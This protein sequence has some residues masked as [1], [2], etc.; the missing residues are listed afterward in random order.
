MS[1]DRRDL[2]GLGL[3][4]GALA[5]AV[6]LRAAVKGKAVSQKIDLWPNGAPEAAPIGLGLSLVERSKDRAIQDRSLMGVTASWLDHIRAKGGNGAAV[7]A[8]P[9]GGYHHLAWDKEGLD[10]AA[11]FAARGVAGFALAYRL[12]LDGWTGGLDTPLADAQRAV[13]VVRGRAAEFGID[14]T[15]IAVIGFSAGGHLAANLAAQFDRTVYPRQDDFDQVSARPDLAAPIYPLV[16]ADR[17]AAAAPAE[18]PPF[19]KAMPPEALTRHSP[20]L[21]ARADAPPH[22]LVHAEDDPLLS[23]EH[24]LALR[25]ALR[26][27][28]VQVETH[29]FAKGGHG[30]GIRNTAGLP[31]AVWPDRLLGFGRSTGWI[32]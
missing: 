1:L 23:P 32:T 11:W 3:S 2:L 20:H 8:I 29:L 13:R 7:I 26:A 24:S 12:P 21:Q 28:A 22:F 5:A 4:V 16:M 25:A 15:R 9:G 31:V 10:I 17:I 14:P 27:K 18:R 19:G 30:F 6:P